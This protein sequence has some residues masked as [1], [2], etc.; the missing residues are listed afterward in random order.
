MQYIILDLEW[1]TAY[2]NLL[3]HFVNEII[4]FGAVKLNKNFEITED[5]SS[6]V[7]PQIEKKLRNRVKNL[8][9]ISNAD[10]A[11]AEPFEVVCEDFTRWVGDLDNTIILSWGDMDIRVLID[12]CKYF[13]ADNPH[14]PFVKYY[15]DLQAYFMAES[16]L[17]KGQQI[18]L[19]NAAALINVNPEE[20]A[21]HRALDDS[22]L[23]SVCF[24]RV[25]KK[26]TFEKAIVTCD[27]EFYT[28]LLFK[29]YIVSDIND[30][31]ID[32]TQF[33][34][35]CIECGEMADQLTDWKFSNSSFHANFICRD[36]NKR[37][38]VNVQFKKNYSQLN[39]KKNVIIIKKEKENARS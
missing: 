11:D 6:F 37:Y 28:R 30:K 21:L 27:D 24:K 34:C 19:A 33:C 4:E 12:N 13:F 29:P 16:D 32:K 15:V 25:Y 2:S 22:E 1:N 18:S 10:V 9:N 35:K 7:K 20:F 31:L 8:T 14:I 26:D 5:F 17:S 36:C 38:R 23:A 3:G 39:I